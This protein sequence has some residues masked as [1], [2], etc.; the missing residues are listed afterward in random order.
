MILN[1]MQSEQLQPQREDRGF[2]PDQKT[3][4]CN[5]LKK[6]FRLN[7][8]VHFFCAIDLEEVERLRGSEDR[9]DIFIILFS[10]LIS[11]KCIDL[12]FKN[13]IHPTLPCCDQSI[14]NNIAT[15]ANQPAWLLFI[16][17]H[18]TENHQNGIKL[19]D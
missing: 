6:H 16:F 5:F 19:A 9:K 10:Q 11:V 3:I 7:V 17:T 8:C 12:G 18:F 13:M 14:Q 15:L 1:S 2:L 4:K